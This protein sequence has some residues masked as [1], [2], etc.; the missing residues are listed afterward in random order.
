MVV[1][2][3]S[4]SCQYRALSC[5]HTI[6]FYHENETN[7]LNIQTFYWADLTFNIKLLESLPICSSGNLILKI[8]SQK[9][10]SKKITS[11]LVI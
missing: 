11:L 10:S 7:I 8:V 6:L 4:L 2:L 3:A 5:Q 9:K 1:S